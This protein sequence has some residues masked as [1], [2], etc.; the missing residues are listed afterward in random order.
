MT[1]TQCRQVCRLA[2]RGARVQEGF[3]PGGASDDGYRPTGANDWPLFFLSYAHSP[4]DDQSGDP[5][6]WV[7]E[8]YNDLCGHI[9]ELADLPKGAQPGFMDRELRQGHECPDR[10][11]KALPTCRVFVPLYS[12]RY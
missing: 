8:L 11:A 5:D 9:R 1:P 2:G 7:G 4:Q 12:K 3:P 6:V 10:L